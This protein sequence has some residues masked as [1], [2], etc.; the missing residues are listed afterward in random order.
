MG[1][2]CCCQAFWSPFNKTPETYENFHFPAFYVET[3]RK[4]RTESKS[5]HCRHEMFV[6]LTVV[7]I[8]FEQISRVSRARRMVYVYLPFCTPPTSFELLLLL[9][10]FDAV[11]EMRSLDV[12]Q[13]TFILTRPK[14]DVDG[15]NRQNI[16]ERTFM[17]HQKLA[18][19]RT[20]VQYA[21]TEYKQMCL[22]MKTVARIANHNFPKILLKVNWI[23][24]DLC[25]CECD[26]LYEARVKWYVHSVCVCIFA[27]QCA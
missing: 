15:K 22:C 25:E 6:I 5:F 18:F 21:H 4:L 16:A 11:C 27:R 10:L 13:Q 8:A 20:I 1:C 9:L 23:A 12:P 14:N 24:A 17:D 2:R 7:C 19:S 3:P 26:C